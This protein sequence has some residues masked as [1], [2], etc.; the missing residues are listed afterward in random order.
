MDRIRSSEVC[1]KN[2]LR[3]GRRRGFA[4]LDVSNRQIGS[5]VS[6]VVLQNTPQSRQIIDHILSP[7]IDR[8]VG[9]EV[10]ELRLAR[11]AE[12]RIRHRT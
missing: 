4:N 2:R 9:G 11:F 10:E 6:V 1:V 3:P 7:E 12:S 8:L 5:V